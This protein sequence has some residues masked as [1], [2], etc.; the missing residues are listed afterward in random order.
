[1]ALAATI[2]VKATPARLIHRASLDMRPFR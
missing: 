2:A 1:V